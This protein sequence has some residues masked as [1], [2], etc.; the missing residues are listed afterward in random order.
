MKENFSAQGSRALWLSSSIEALRDSNFKDLTYNPETGEVSAESNEGKI[1]I[2]VLPETDNSA[3]LKIES[4]SNEDINIYKKKVAQEYA[5][6][7]DLPQDI[8]EERVEDPIGDV[9]TDIYEEIFSNTET[10]SLPSKPNSPEEKEDHESN[11]EQESVKT[12]KKWYQTEWF[13]L[14]ISIIVPPLGI[15]LLWKNKIF[16]EPERKMLTG[17]F[18]FYTVLWIWLLSLPFIPRNSEVILT[19]NT[20]TNSSLEQINAYWSQEP[21]VNFMA[22]MPELMSS[23]DDLYINNEL[24]MESGNEE[25][26]QIYAQ[27]T[28]LSNSVLQVSNLQVSNPAFTLQQKVNEAANLFNVAVQEGST[29]LAS[30]DLVEIDTSTIA[31]NNAENAFYEISYIYN[32]AVQAAT[33]ADNAAQNSQATTENTEDITDSVTEEQP[34]EEIITETE[35]NEIPPEDS[36]VY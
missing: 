33:S 25:A 2:T 19:E 32:Q 9:G 17:F 4:G 18:C 21:V 29:A 8:L 10:T 13:A 5:K 11:S 31:W 7:R 30:G 35:I 28:E 12:S 15:Y 36:T 34:V 23:Y 16:K 14:L 22:Q 26:N 24:G 3:I 6:L 20:D 27:V 1:T